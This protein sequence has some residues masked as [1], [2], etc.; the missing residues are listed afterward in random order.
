MEGPCDGWM[1]KL[2]NTASI[3]LIRFLSLTQVF[4]AFKERL[5]E[6][7][8][9][10]NL[11]ALEAL[12]KII[13][14]LKDNLAQVVYILVPAVVDNHLNSKNNS[15]YTAATGAIH[16]LISNLGGF[17]A[18]HQT[19]ALHFKQLSPYGKFHLNINYSLFLVLN[20]NTSPSVYCS[21]M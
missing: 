18:G 1:Q 12:Q 17:L 11:Y 3:R 2:Y 21:I 15:I 5:Q 8:S 20:K 4:D 16:A 10:V 13:T 14:L 9:K 7:N 19:L 6:S